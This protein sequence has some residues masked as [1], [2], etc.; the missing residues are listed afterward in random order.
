[1]NAR[2][3]ILLGV[4]IVL[5]ACYVLFNTEW[6]QPDPIQIQA[7]VRDISARASLESPRRLSREE[8]EARKSEARSRAQRGDKTSAPTESGRFE[9]VYPVVFALDGE[10]RLT[11]IRVIEDQPSVPGRAPL[12]VWQLNTSSNSA[13]TKALLYGK[14]P[15][16]MKLK[17]ERNKPARLQ[18]GVVYRLE[19]QAGRYKGA[20]TFQTKETVPPDAPAG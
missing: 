2:I 19:V 14:T 13:P 11:A 15:R 3:W 20:T 5:G 6:L 16:G 7:Q 9:G 12:I 1:M 10:Y 4:T 8:R 17:D 18:P